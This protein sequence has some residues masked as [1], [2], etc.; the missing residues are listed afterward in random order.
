MTDTTSR[1]RRRRLK[2]VLLAGCLILLFVRFGG[3]FQTGAIF[4]LLPSFASDSDHDMAG[5]YRPLHKGS[6]Y[7][8][9]GLYVR[10]NEDLAVA[11]TPL[12]LRRT[13]L[14]RYHDKRQFGIGTTHTGEWWL[15]AEDSQ[16]GASR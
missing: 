6:I 16:L 14:S 1:P 2:L 15:Y 4:F 3:A 13:Y 8:G 5:N 12:V 7:L 9:T 10:V 11:G